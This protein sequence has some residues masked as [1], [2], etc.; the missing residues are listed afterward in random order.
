M[1]EQLEQLL[2][3]AIGQLKAQGTLP[4]DL[5]VNIKLD[6]PRDK[7]HGDFATTSRWC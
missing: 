2:A 5:P 1:K 4:D 7:S 3:E 6:R